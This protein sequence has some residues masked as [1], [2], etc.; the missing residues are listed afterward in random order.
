MRSLMDKSMAV[1]KKLS[2]NQ[3]YFGLK[4]QKSSFLKKSGFE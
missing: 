3:Q 4:M 2:M 1:F